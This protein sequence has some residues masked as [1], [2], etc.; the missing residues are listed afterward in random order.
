MLKNLDHIKN[1]DVLTKRMYREVL[2]YLNRSPW[3]DRVYSSYQHIK[4][5]E[6]TIYAGF[7]EVDLSKGSRTKEGCKPVEIKVVFKW[8]ESM[9]EFKLK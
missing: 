2:E 8:W 3:P 5:E 6:R 1:G 7:I 4:P 9:D